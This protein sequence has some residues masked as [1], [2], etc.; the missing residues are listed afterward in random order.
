MAKKLQGIH[1]FATP[2]ESMLSRVSMHIVI[3]NML[4]GFKL[5]NLRVKAMDHAR[6]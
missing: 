5:R 2:E 1:Y 6:M 4:V 3:L